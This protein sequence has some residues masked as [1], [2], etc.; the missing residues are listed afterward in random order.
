MKTLTPF[1]DDAVSI[2][3]GDASGRRSTGYPASRSAP[4]E[5]ADAVR[6]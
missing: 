4:N 5:E 2:G 6:G 1:S 3:I